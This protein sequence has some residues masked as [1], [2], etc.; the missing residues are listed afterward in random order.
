MQSGIP[1]DSQ[2]GIPLDE[3]TKS[4]PWVHSGVFRLQNATGK[5]E[6]E[7][8]ELLKPEEELLELEEELLELDEELLEPDEVFENGEPDEELLEDTQITSRG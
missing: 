2:V 6:P 1:D 7:E 4:N 8:D 5:D 3:Q